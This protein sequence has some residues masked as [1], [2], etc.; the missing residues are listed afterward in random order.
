MCLGSG[1]EFDAHT[2]CFTEDERYAAKGTEVG[3]PKKG[4]AKQES[5]VDMIRSILKEE[6]RMKPPHRNMLNK[7]ACFN[8]VPRKKP[9]FIVSS[10]KVVCSC[11]CKTFVTELY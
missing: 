3:L 11:I 5:W 9:K 6:P 4:E 1:D 2:K 7:I 10:M 8:N